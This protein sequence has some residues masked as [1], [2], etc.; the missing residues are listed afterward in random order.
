MKLKHL[1]LGFFIVLI[2]AGGVMVGISLANGGDAPAPPPDE[3]LAVKGYTL[4][5][6]HSEHDG[7]W[8]YIIRGADLKMI[9]HSRIDGYDTQEDAMHAAIG[10]ITCD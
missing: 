2:V 6:I 10:L 1:P 4:Q 3:Q 5:M 9:V 7:R 8:R